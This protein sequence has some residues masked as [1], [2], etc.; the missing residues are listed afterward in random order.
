MESN[1]TSPSSD[2]SHDPSEKNTSVDWHSSQAMAKYESQ[3][4]GISRRWLR[5]K[6]FLKRFVWN[7]VVKSTLLI[8][9]LMDIIASLIAIILLSPIFIF[10]WIAIKVE[11]PGPAIFTQQRVG[12]WG[13]SFTMFKFRSMVMNAD[14]MK[15][16]LM[17]QNESEAG[18]I[19]KMKEDPRITKVGKWIRKFSVDELPQLFNVLNGDMSLVGP[20]PPTSNEVAQYSLSD[21][22]R[23]DVVP[24]IT[25]IW[26]VSGRSDIDF[27]GQVRLDVQY[28]QSQSVWTDLVILLKTIPAVLMG[29]GAY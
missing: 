6:F 4:S 5:V 20:R 24:G 12:R 7:S 25:C 3:Q 11:D 29:K 17:D 27:E 18:V 16:E 22:R 21:R 9:R 28:I 14:K 2:P 1:K 13:K 19:F 8:K 10:T 15:A 23:L 26:Q